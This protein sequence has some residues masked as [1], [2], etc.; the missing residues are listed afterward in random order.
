M[1]IKEWVVQSL[2]LMLQKVDGKHL[3]GWM[4]YTLSSTALPIKTGGTPEYDINN[5][6][7]VYGI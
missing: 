2:E 5:M 3:E 7:N 1:K 4:T 6:L